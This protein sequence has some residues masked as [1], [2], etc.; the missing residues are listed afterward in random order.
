M[1]I[2]S[3]IDKLQY[4]EA[5][6]IPV[7]AQDS[8]T[9]EVRMSAWADRE[10]LLVSAHQME[11]HYFSRS[12]N[13]LWKKGESSGDVQKLIGMLPDCDMDSVLYLIEQTGAGACH[14]GARN[15]FSAKSEPPRKAL[16]RGALPAAAVLPVLAEIIAARR[17]SDA[18]NSYTAK[19]LAG[20]VELPARKVGE[21]AQEVVLAAV[22]GQRDKLPQEAADL[23][24]HLLVL[25]EQ[26]QVPLADVLAVLRERMK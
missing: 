22:Q 13:R 12:R 19:L 4:N 24:Y 26:Q 15:C 2:K 18:K 23:L 21:E 7:I 11:A 3:W 6:L 17:G 14:T 9:G 1:N 8:R 20:G 25:L 5:G 10:A 16:E